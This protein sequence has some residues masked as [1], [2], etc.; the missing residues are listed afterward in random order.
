MAAIARRATLAAVLPILGLGQP[1]PSTTTTTTT[2]TTLIFT[3]DV[4]SFNCEPGQ[5]CNPNGMPRIRGLCVLPQ[6]NIQTSC[7]DVCN[8]SHAPEDYTMTQGNSAP[9]ILNIAMAG[10]VEQVRLGLNPAVRCPGSLEAFLGDPCPLGEFCPGGMRKAFHIKGDTRGI[11]VASPGSLGNRA[12]WDVCSTKQHPDF[13]TG[14][15]AGTSARVASAQ[16]SNCHGLPWWAWVMIV[17]LIVAVLSCIF[18]AVFNFL[19]NRRRGGRATEAYLKDDAADY[20]RGYEDNYPPQEDYPQDNFPPLPEPPAVSPKK[21]ALG[22]D[23]DQ[24]FDRKPQ[25]FAGGGTHIPGLEQP[26]GLA[27]NSF[28]P[29]GAFSQAGGS[30]PRITSQTMP[31]MYSY[32]PSAQ[33]PTGTFGTQPPSTYVTPHSSMQL[34]PIQQPAAGAFF[35][36]LQRR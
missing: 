13:L 8:P 20:D 31:A 14:T 17:M 16:S 26:R 25:Q 15:P 10:L 7:W 1:W 21:R 29:L 28:Q 32:G 36:Q 2:T 4:N 22:Y 30:P 6:G 24:H 5:G 12:C 34:R 11:C 18:A 3:P 9:K 23:E 19:R 35:S 33:V 27:V